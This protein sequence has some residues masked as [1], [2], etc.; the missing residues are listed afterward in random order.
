MVR[1]LRRTRSGSEALGFSQFHS[2]SKA[3]QATVPLRPKFSSP[4]TPDH[5]GP[6]DFSV[7]KPDV[8][9]IGIS[10]LENPRALKVV[11]AQRPW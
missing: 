9:F 4:G 2:S 1:S 6:S 7:P 3:S 11:L 8:P 10:M 5:T